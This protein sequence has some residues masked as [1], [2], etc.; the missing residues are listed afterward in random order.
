ML[1]GFAGGSKYS[2]GKLQVDFGNLLLAIGRQKMF[3]L[4]SID[5]LRLLK[6]AQSS[7]GEGLAKLSPP[8]PGTLRELLLELLESFHRLLVLLIQIA[9]SSPQIAQIIVGRLGI[10]HRG[11][12]RPHRLDELALL[13]QFANL[14]IDQGGVVLTGQWLFRGRRVRWGAAS[15]IDGDSRRR[16][17]RRNQAGSECR[18]QGTN[19]QENR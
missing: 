3:R 4:L 11:F 5:R 18:D 8:E 1:S 16:F 9:G 14:D 17:I 15:R 19:R 12:D 2:I 10:L 6:V 13:H 7:V